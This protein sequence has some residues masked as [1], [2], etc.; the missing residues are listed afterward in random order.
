MFGIIIYDIIFFAI[1]TILILFFGISFYRYRQAKQI[2]KEKPGTFSDEEIKKRKIFLIISAI[3]AG[4]LAAVAV[5]FI[6][7]LYMDIAFM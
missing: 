6:V 3:L 5:G 4:I 1:P 7:L 2:N